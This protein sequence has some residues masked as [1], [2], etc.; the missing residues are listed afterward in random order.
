MCYWFHTCKILSFHH[1]VGEVFAV[2]GSCTAAMGYFLLTFW[3]TLQSHLQRSQCSGRELEQVGAWIYRDS[4]TGDWLAGKV[5]DTNQTAVRRYK[6]WTQSMAGGGRWRINHHLWPIGVKMLN[7]A[8]TGK[9]SVIWSDY[10]SLLCKIPAEQRPCFLLVLLSY[11]SGRN[12]EM[13]A[14]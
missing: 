12:T 10:Q 14:A 13:E 4:F 11:L 9:Q 2:L 7:N 3:D 6:M 1:S 8:H 5:T